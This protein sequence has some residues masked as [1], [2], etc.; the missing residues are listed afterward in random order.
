MK[1]C[2]IAGASDFAAHTLPREGDYIVAADGGYAALTARGFAPDLV[3]GDF[4]SLGAAPEHPNVVALPTEKDDTDLFAAVKLALSRGCG[5]FI[6]N[7]AL[8]GR[9]DHTLGGI[10][11]LAYA[12]NAG[13]R[14]VLAGEG[15]NVTL[16]RGGQARFTAAAT[17]ILSVFAYGGAARVSIAGMRYLAEELQLKPDVPRG[18]SNEFLGVPARVTAHEGLLLLTWSGEIYTTLEGYYD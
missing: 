4:D 5:E 1:R 14:G 6:I 3:V 8:G 2:Y 7:G 18:V 13:A 10:H 11:A 15:M 12:V 9:L 17:G 16:V